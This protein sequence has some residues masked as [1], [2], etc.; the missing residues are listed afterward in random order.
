MKMIMKRY[1]LMI[2]AVWAFCACQHDI[3][4]AVDFNVTFDPANTYMAGKPVRFNISGDV[5]NLLFFSGEH[6]A[7]YANTDRTE[8]PMSAVTDLTINAEYMA[9]YAVP[10]HLEIWITDNFDG[11]YSTGDPQADSTSFASIA[12][13]PAA[14]GWL[15][16]NY[17]EGA[18]TQWTNETYSL[19]DSTGFNIASDKL[20]LAFH[21]CAPENV[22][23]QRQYGLNGTLKY[24]AAGRIFTKTYKDLGFKTISLNEDTFYNAATYNGCKFQ[25]NT[26]DAQIFFNGFDTIADKSTGAVKDGYISPYRWDLWMVSTPFKTI[27]VDPDKGTVIKNVQNALTTF[28]HTWKEPGTYTVVFVGTCANYLGS[29]KQVKTLTVNILETVENP[30]D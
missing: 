18:N 9:K 11:L 17:E 1:I 3:E 27:P 25:Y 15:R 23:F 14:A 8:L 2:S 13:D 28:E 29:S 30:L 4:R 20:C 7:E 22:T 12:S 16:L 10:G 24:E 6:G 5:D 26:K 19:S 21:W